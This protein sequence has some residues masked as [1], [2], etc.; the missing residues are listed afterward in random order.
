MTVRR[1]RK[2]PPPA[3]EYLDRATYDKRILRHL[4]GRFHEWLKSERVTISNI[5]A[6]HVEQFL[7]QDRLCAVAV[8]TKLLYPR[9]LH[10]YLRWL[11]ER[12]FIGP[13]ACK[14]YRPK[15]LPEPARRFIQQLKPILRPNSCE[16]YRYALG[17]FFRWSQSLGVDVRA[18]KRNDIVKFTGFLYRQG[19]APGTRCGYLSKLHNYLRYLHRQGLLQGDPEFLIRSTDFPKIPDCLPRALRPE[20]DVQLCVR[21]ANS[22]DLRCQGLLVMR[23]TGLRI[24]ELRT[25]P[26]NCVQNDHLGNRDLKVPLGKLNNERL[27]P[28]DDETY[29]LIEQI[30]MRDPQPRKWLIQ[31][32]RTGQPFHY[33]CYRESLRLVA[34]DITNGDEAITTHQLRHHAE[35]RIMPRRRRPCPEAAVIPANCGARERLMSA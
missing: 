9:H 26:L 35:P 22:T 14:T 32:P 34:H 12:R 8:S 20:V 17:R 3:S 11:A 24:D 4:L 7:D 30:K 29:D 28:I 21:L 10:R 5:H 33:T 31:N 13:D 1:H 27:V 23:N 25:L 6:D 15:P 2:L 16:Q 19:L 18:L